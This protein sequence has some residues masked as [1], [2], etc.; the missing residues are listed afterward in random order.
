MKISVLVFLL[1]LFASCSIFQKTQKNN[2][3]SEIDSATHNVTLNKLTDNGSIKNYSK[4]NVY[5]KSGIKS[6]VGTLFGYPNDLINATQQLANSTQK[7]KDSTAKNDILNKVNL[8]PGDELHV[9][10]E[11]WSNEQKELT[12]FDKEDKKA[13]VK[14]EDE[15]SDV[16]IEGSS[17]LVMILCITAGFVIII[18]VIFLFLYYK[19]GNSLTGIFKKK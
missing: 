6:K 4:I 13:A 18:I 9:S 1:A 15:K 17:K 7:L 10:I 2:D 14:K 16:Q 8:P 12:K 19:S 11:S 5:Y 3:K